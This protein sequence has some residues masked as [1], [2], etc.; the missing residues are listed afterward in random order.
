MDGFIDVAG[1]GV[2]DFFEAGEV[3]EVGELAALERLDWLNSAIVAVEKDALP[4]GFILEGE[5]ATID[6][7]AGVL[8]DEIVLGK[9]AKAGN[10]GDF[11][12]AEADL[13]GPPTAGGATLALVEDRHAG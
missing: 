6:G 13:A 7:E 5:S 2:T 3:P 9:V 8:L 11:R 10:A 4:V 1:E 12:L